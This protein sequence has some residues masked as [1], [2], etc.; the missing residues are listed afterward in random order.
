MVVTSYGK[1]IRTPV[2][3]I[4]ELGRATQGVRLIRLS[5]D[6]VVVGTARIDDPSDEDDIEGV[7]GAAVEGEA[8]EGEAAEGEAAEG[9]AAEDEGAEDEAD[10][11]A[12]GEADGE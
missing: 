3:G 8:V 4:S 11:G 10:E 7:E 1:L 2:A 6:E 12:E 5:E 9:E